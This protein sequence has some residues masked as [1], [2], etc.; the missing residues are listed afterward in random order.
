[1]KNVIIIISRIKK[2]KKWV[3]GMLH[4]VFVSN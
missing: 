4:E 1:M 2:V 3:V